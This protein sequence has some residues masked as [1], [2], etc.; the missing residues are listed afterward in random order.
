MRIF[1]L[2]TETTDLIKQN[3]KLEEQPYIVEFAGLVYEGYDLV[4]KIHFLCK[5]PVS[6]L[7][8]SSKIH[9]IDD[10]KVKDMEPIGSKLAVI[11]AQMVLADIIVG[12]NISFDMN[13]L[14][15]E[16]CR[17]KLQK[18]FMQFKEKTYCTMKET[19][20]LLKI[21]G[22][23]GKYKWGKL[24]DLHLHLFGEEFEHAHSA[25]ADIEAT[26]KCFFE[27]YKQGKVN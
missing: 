16:C 10:E 26:A 20:E 9:G 17:H 18:D 6:I 12:H 21:P 22:N 5:P 7:T 14:W 23:Y 24:Q 15:F 1:F 27:L 25:L 11:I 13:M 19:T 4:E 2:D 8:S 3:A